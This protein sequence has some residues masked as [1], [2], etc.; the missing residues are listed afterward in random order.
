MT[1]M[2]YLAGVLLVAIAAHSLAGCAGGD[3]VPRDSADASATMTPERAVN[4][5]LDADRSF[6]TA[7]AGADAVAALTAMFADDVRLPA[8]DG[9]IARGRDAA[10]ALLRTNPDNATSRVE[11]TPIRGGVSAD[12]EH[13]FTIGYMTL[14]RPD[15]LKVPM[16]Y[17]AYWTRGADGWRVA[18]YRRSRR[19]EGEVSLA[20]L[21][22]A[23]PERMQAVLTDSAVI[24]RFAGE[25][26]E[27]ERT[28]SRDAQGGRAIG[29]AFAAHGSADAANMGGPTSPGFVIGAEAIGES[30]AEGVAGLSSITWEPE[31]VIVA[32]SGDL[33]VTIGTITVV[34]PPPGGGA[35]VPSK[36][37]Y[38]T[39][40]RRAR[41]GAPWKYVAE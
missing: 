33:G 29:E 4:E 10:M 6:S 24:A 16:K 27:A 17:V 30:V 38:F 15:S 11:W 39:V 21:P 13:G 2:N 22:P 5:L 41:P 7:A 9:S 28:F 35:A 8:P 25:L 3:S 12:G 26:M 23:L 34:A 40:W 20:M 1:S 14:T 36:V 18:V 31:N 37:P 32:S 19:P